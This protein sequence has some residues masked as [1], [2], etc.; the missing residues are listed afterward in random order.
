M[1][2]P[3]KAKTGRGAR[4][5]D[6]ESVQRRSQLEA[7]QRALTD[8]VVGNVL[9]YRDDRGLSNDQLRAR[10][11]TLGWELTK[12]SLASVLSGSSKRKI[13]PLGDVF[14]FALALNVPPIA[15]VFPI[16]TNTPVAIGPVPPDPDL[17]QTVAFKAA[18][19]FS[20]RDGDVVLP[21]HPGGHDDT[22]D[23]YYS[24]GDL[25]GRIDDF[26]MTQLSFD[27]VNAS[28]IA[29]Q[30]GADDRKAL[31]G[32]ALNL[33]GDLSRQ[34][35]FLQLTNPELALAP[36]RPSLRFIEYDGPLYPT[37]PLIGYSTDAEILEAKDAHNFN[38]TDVPPA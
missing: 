26:Q 36:L 23:E 3:E 2:S 38:S 4:P 16:H 18:Q 30:Q 20:G 14:L 13:M 33:L 5:T 1:T 17:A 28:L 34:R 22:V 25:L 11:A 24:V 27:R 10:L 32:T 15:L 12:D 8:Q 35:R 21:A 7:W 29:G 37:L 19:W 9:H 31:L 6:Q